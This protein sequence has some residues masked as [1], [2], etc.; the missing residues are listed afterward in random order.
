MLDKKQLLRIL[1]VTP[2]YHPYVGGIETHVL[3]VTR[4]LVGP[5]VAVTVLTTDPSGKLSAN[6]TVD[7]VEILRVRAWPA[8]RDYYF[9][10]HL[11]RVMA[12]QRWDILH[13]QG[14]HTLVPPLA[15]ITARRLGLPYVVT[16]HSGGSS[17][18][19]RGVLRP[20]QWQALR[21]LLSQAK[22][23]IAPSVWEAEYFQRRLLLPMERFSVIP[24]GAWQIA[25]V[26]NT[27]PSTSDEKLILSVG[28]LERYKGHQRV[29]AAMPHV[30]AQVPHARLR[31]IGSGPYERTL[32]RRVSQ[33]GLE[34]KVEIAAI[35]PGD[36]IGMAGLLLRADVVTLLSEH[37]AQG[38]AVMDA[39]ALRRPVVVAE[40]T[41]LQEFVA[42]GY[43]LGVPLG[44]PAN[45]VAAAILRQL[46]MPLMPLDIELPTWD[47]C[48]ASLLA[49]YR[50]ATC[51]TVDV[52]S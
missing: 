5:T 43:A 45:V 31:I 16:F 2:R 51:G 39:L 21:P 44:A 3:E 41:A 22:E 20:A 52:S 6:E 25:S 19:I 4:R 36:D 37:E 50:R 38:L 11:P 48:A 12:E 8:H 14:C 15:M 32:R 33:L 17:S 1:M 28:R 18:R 49:L 34:E 23:L 40:T 24:N 10:P 26:M 30:L 27:W 29:I 42:K 13:C 46:D 9:A 7:G 47:N 35:P